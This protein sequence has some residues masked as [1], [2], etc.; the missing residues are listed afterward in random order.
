[1]TRMTGEIAVATGNR[2]VALEYYTDWSVAALIAQV[3]VEIDG[4]LDT[5]SDHR[6]RTPDMTVLEPR[7]SLKELNAKYVMVTPQLTIDHDWLVL[8]CPE[9]NSHQVF[10]IGAAN[11]IPTGCWRSSETSPN[12]HLRPLYRPPRPWAR[13]LH[14]A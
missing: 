9:C 11:R 1:M 6:L 2:D 4:D 10:A 7:D 14:P 8:A 5:L 3:L 13:P 12:Q